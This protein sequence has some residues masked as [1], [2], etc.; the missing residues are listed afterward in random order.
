MIAIDPVCGMPIDSEMAIF[1]AEIRNGTYYFCSE[2]HRRSFLESPRIAYFSMEIGIRSDTPTYSGGLGV[3]AGDFIRSGAD[4]RIPLVAVTLVS[5][6]G[7]FRQQ[8]TKS[9]DQIEYPDDWVPSSFMRL[10]PNTVTVPI[11]GRIVKI[12]SWLYD[13]QSLAG[14]LVPI[15]FLDTDILE[16]DPADRSITNFLYGGDDR[17]RLKQEMVLGIGGVR[18][19]SELNFKISKYHMN[20][21]HSSLLTLELLKKNSLD[22]VRTKDICVFTTHTPVEAAFD[23]FSYDDVKTI[24]GDEFPQEELKKY[25]GPDRLNMTL[26]ALNLSKYVNGVTNAHMEYSKNLFP[27]YH[28]RAITNGVHPYTWTCKSFRKL[29]DSQ[30][31]GWANE[32]ELLVRADE[33]SRQKIW[34]AH[35]EAK[36]TLIDYIRRSTG[37]DLDPNILTLGFARR[38]T[39]YKRAALIF[40]DIDRLRD[41]NNRGRLQ[42][43]IAGKAHPRD[44]VGKSIIKK[45]YGY[46]SQLQGKLT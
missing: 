23:K 2:D 42:I 1:K 26:L 33:I 28:L 11:D 29:F 41:I 17:Y 3:L 9:G 32:P 18:M 31:P 30:I 38:A 43:I 39:E 44:E 20:E 13:L 24:L 45:I 10:L 22:P 25:A 15:L 6:K 21:G 8:I 35:F 4:L 5:R 14:G 37:E 34:Q 36:K 19:L 7:Y 40:S 46:R 12:R 27:G 16:N